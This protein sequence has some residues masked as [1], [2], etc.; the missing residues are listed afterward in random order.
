MFRR[1]YVDLKGMGATKMDN[2]Q[3]IPKNFHKNLLEGAFTK[4]HFLCDF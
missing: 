3:Y 1:P 4:E 2:I